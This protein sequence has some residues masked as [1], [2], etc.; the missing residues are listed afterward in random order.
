VAGCDLDQLRNLSRILFGQAL[1][2]EVMVA[3]AR[4]D[5][6][7]NLTDLATAIGV[8]NAS[9]I[10]KPLD[11]LKAGG[12][13]VEA[14]MSDSR[15]HWLRRSDSLVWQWVVELAA[16]HGYETVPQSGKQQSRGVGN[17]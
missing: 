7:V 17:R 6:L 10:Q 1:R 15:R 9:R 4:S 5:G 12:L 2:L 11:D 16:E 14:E 3:I 13:L 8:Q